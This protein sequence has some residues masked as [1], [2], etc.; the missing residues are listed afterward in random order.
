MGRIESNSGDKYVIFDPE[1]QFNGNISD[2]ENEC[3]KHSAHLPNVEEAKYVAG[4]NYIITSSTSA[5][6]MVLY[7]PEY[8]A[9]AVP[10]FYNYDDY[11]DLQLYCIID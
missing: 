4:T 1:F 7:I 9:T 10:E 5:G 6:N 8:E 11:N 2:A 3:K